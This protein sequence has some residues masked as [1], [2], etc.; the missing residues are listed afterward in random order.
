MSSTSTTQESE[1]ALLE[2]CMAECSGDVK[3]VP[4]EGEEDESTSS[5][6]SYSARVSDAWDDIRRAH[7]IGHSER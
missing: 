3:I 4:L 6:P 2:Q 5:S 7:M 1:R